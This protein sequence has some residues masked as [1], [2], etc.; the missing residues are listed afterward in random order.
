[1]PR[2]AKLRMCMHDGDTWESREM[3]A[4]KHDDPSIRGAVGTV[5][6]VMENSPKTSGKFTYFL[7]NNYE[8]S[9]LKITDVFVQHE[10]GGNATAR[11]I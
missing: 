2:K 11:P 8:K 3:S 7:F 9:C 4:L 6:T 10:Q 5:E 1:M